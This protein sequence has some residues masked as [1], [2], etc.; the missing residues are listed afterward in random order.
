MQVVQA[1]DGMAIERER[2][3]IIP[4][5]VYLS[6]DGKRDLAAFAT[7]GAPRRAVAVRLPAEFVGRR[8]RRARRLR[9]PS[10]TGADGSEG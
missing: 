5:G 8:F 2:V 10:G 6:A 4:P 3:H 7:A 9:R 1:T